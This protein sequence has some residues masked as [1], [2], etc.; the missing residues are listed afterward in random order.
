MHLPKVPLQTC[1]LGRV[2]RFV[3][4]FVDDKWEVAEDDSQMRA[5]FILDFLKGP[6]EPTTWWTLEVAEFF[7]RDRSISRSA[8]VH[9]TA[10]FRCE[11]LFL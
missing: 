8:D 4:V 5:V 2:G 7:N 11:R 6:G 10:R 3:S 1:R 9:G